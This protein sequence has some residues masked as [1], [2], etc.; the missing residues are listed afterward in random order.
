MADLRSAI[1]AGLEMIELKRQE[2][3]IVEQYSPEQART[4]EKVVADIE[5]VIQV[6]LPEWFSNEGNVPHETDRFDLVGD[7]Y[8]PEP[9]L[10]ARDVARILNVGMG[11]VYELPIPRLRLG[12]QRIRW[13]PEDVR[14]YIESFPVEM[15]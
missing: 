11:R 4:I 10:T 2:A 15:P 8:D 13:R 14:A 5:R 6:N 9:L 7:G 1:D 12:P 3:K